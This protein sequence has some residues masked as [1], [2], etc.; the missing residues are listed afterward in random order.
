MA[1]SADFSL[2][3]DV[4]TENRDCY[5]DSICIIIV[6]ALWNA[7][8]PSWFARSIVLTWL[9]HAK[10]VFLVVQHASE[11]WNMRMQHTEINSFPGDFN[12]PKCSITR[13]YK[14][15]YA[16]DVRNGSC[17]LRVEAIKMKLQHAYW[18]K[19]RRFKVDR[20]EVGHSQVIHC[21]GKRYRE[22]KEKEKN[23]E[24]GCD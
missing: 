9:T 17:F 7:I 3:G 1:T 5:K 6:L 13:V 10:R 4:V 16:K 24:N 2:T 19:S 18:Y 14:T 15:P 12:D 21:H 8:K 11:K 20:L 22:R 23:D